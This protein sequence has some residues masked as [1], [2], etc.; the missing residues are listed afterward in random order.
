MDAR[1]RN[2]PPRRRG[3]VLVL[4]LAMLGLLALIGVTFATFSGQ[5]QVG[6]RY[7]AEG[8]AFP[9]S[10][11][12][13]DFGLLNLINDSNNPTSAIRG[14]SLKR[15][16]YGNGADKN[17]YVERELAT[18]L[19]L[20]VSNSPAPTRVNNQVYLTT[21]IPVGNTAYIGFKFLGW[22]LKTYA[23]GTFQVSQTFKIVGDDQS[24][25]YRAFLLADGPEGNTPTATLT[26]PAAGVSFVLDGRYL[27]AFNGGGMNS[28]GAPGAATMTP[29]P[30][31]VPPSPPAVPPAPILRPDLSPVG[32]FANFRYNNGIIND[33]TNNYLGG[34]AE[35]FDF[36]N[37]FTRVA[38]DEDYDAP[39]L[40]NWF[41]AMQSADGQVVIPSFHRPSIIR[42]DENP[43]TPANLQV[44]DWKNSGTEVRAKFLRPRRIDHPGSGGSFP[45]LIPDATTGRITYDIDNDGD[46]VTDSVWLDFGAP[47]QRSATGKLFKAL[48]APMVLG[49]NGRLPLNSAGNLHLRGFDGGLLTGAHP[50]HA[51]HLG[52]STSEINIKY[53]L[54]NHF[55]W[56]P[57]SPAGSDQTKLGGF[58]S[59]VDNVPLLG[60]NTDVS[61]TQLRNLLVGNRPLNYPNYPPSAAVNYAP[62]TTMPASGDGNPVLVNGVLYYLAN[63]YYDAVVTPGDISA[64]RGTAAVPGR[65]GEPSLIPTQNNALFLEFNNPVRAG[66]SVGFLENPPAFPNDRYGI[67]ATDDDFDT[68]DFF[69]LDSM[70]NQAAGELRNLT[71][72]AGYELLPVERIRAFVTPIDPS[73]NGVVTRFNEPVALGLPPHGQGPDA[74]GRVSYFHYFRPPGKLPNVPT[75]P[76]LLNNLLHGLEAQRLPL[77]DSHAQ[78]AAMP[79]D[80]L[81]SNG[82]DV[83]TY[84]ADSPTT[85]GVNSHA[86]A[87]SSTNIFPSGGLAKDLADESNLYQPSRYDALFGPQDL[88][89]LYRQH[90]VDGASLD[91]RLKYLAPISFNH[92]VDGQRRRRLFSLETWETNKYIARTGVDAGIDGQNANFGGP[93][94]N[95]HGS[96]L[97][98]PVAPIVN[99]TAAQQ[100]SLPYYSR[101][102][103]PA[104]TSY[105]D[106]G[107]GVGFA[108]G[109]P[110]LAGSGRRMNLNLPLPAQVIDNTKTP[111]VQACDETVRHRWILDAYLLCRAVLP[112]ANNYTPEECVQLSQFLTNVIDFRDTD[113]VM[114]RFVNPEVIEQSGS[115]AAV[116]PTM[117]KLRFVNDATVPA[118]PTAAN[119]TF[120]PVVQWGMEYN[121]IAINE[122]LATQFNYMTNTPSQ[123]FFIELV[124]T[125]TRDG[126]AAGRAGSKATD[127]DLSKWQ[128]TF[129]PDGPAGR[130]DPFTG[131][132]PSV[133]P[134]QTP[135]TPVLMP[136]TPIA[137]SRAQALEAVDGTTIPPRTTA[138]GAEDI[139]AGGPYPTN[140]Y[141]VAGTPPVAANADT[142]RPARNADL[143][144]P[145]GA[146]PVFGNT[147]TP[148]YGQLPRL[149]FNQQAYY[150]VYLLR[151][152]DPTDANSPLAPV[153][154]MR[155]LMRESS[156]TPPIVST[157]PP[158]ITG[159]TP[160]PASWQRLQPYRGG[161]AIGQVPATVAATIDPHYGLSEQTEASPVVSS[162]QGQW[163]SS[164]PPGQPAAPAVY[165]T[166][167]ARNTSAEAWDYLAFHDRDFMGVAE[168]LLVP[169]CPPNLFTKQFVENPSHR[170]LPTGTLFGFGATPG[171]PNTP[172]Y[173]PP[174]AFAVNDPNYGNPLG[175]PAGGLPSQVNAV[176]VSPTSTQDP[177]AYPYL[178]DKFYYNDSIP[179]PATGHD[180]WYQMLEYFEVPSSAIG[181]VGRVAYGENLDWQRQ[182]RRPGQ[183]NLNLIIDEEVF[184][185]L[186]DDARLDTSNVLPRRAGY[187][188]P[189]VATL[190]RM[191]RA[192]INTYPF[193]QYVSPTNAAATYDSGSFQVTSAGVNQSALKQSFLDFLK[194][195]HG[196]SNDLFS[197]TNNVPALDNTGTPLASASEVSPK[198]YRALSSANIDN[199]ILRPA[200][201]QN[202]AVVTQS[203]PLDPGIRLR[204]LPTVGAT[205]NNR[206]R[207]VLPTRRL[208]QVPD[209][210]NPLTTPTASLSTA[211]ENPPYLQAGAFAPNP[212]PQPVVVF[213]NHMNL[214]NTSAN[215]WAPRVGPPPVPPDFPLYLGGAN[216]LASVP[217]KG[218]TRQHPA[219]RVETLEKMMN[220][221]T[222]RTHQFAVWFTV[223]FFEV[224]QPGNPAGVFQPLTQ[225]TA[226][227]PNPIDPALDQLGQ[228]I[229]LSTGRN[230][231]YRS[232]FLVDRTR[233]T[234][235]NSHNPTDFRE[236]VTYRRRIE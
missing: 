235:L 87:H 223:G 81:A 133:F 138:A 197:Y 161:H 144:S 148:Q 42:V 17:G 139:V 222:T 85:V 187:V 163:Q 114:T 194:L 175:Y 14:H 23:P 71:D 27:H 129:L 153:D 15:D 100:T 211:S 18:G 11:E 4:I 38:M 76:D 147:L 124:N 118:L 90:D 171:A 24:G 75:G 64:I 208:F 41:L 1:Y 233:A 230:I 83:P 204:F 16:M 39:D 212:P 80:L 226:L 141:Y 94:V 20:T 95:S 21:N 36:S 135:A 25:T 160:V 106:D 47:V 78:M 136:I 177:H 178:V 134:A 97:A 109:S 181:A 123:E 122:V 120:G 49:L 137:T 31:P 151:P 193:N 217:P 162:F 104:G 195:R 3:V 13:M 191:D 228:E 12:V 56:D 128:L 55:Q 88:E 89:W 84:Y 199:T 68:D 176:G 10:D 126:G 102:F 210:A 149:G 218:D 190:S 152:S 117:P 143:A 107:A 236:C 33:G 51:S 91:S 119:S 2:M 43:L 22:T 40:E 188:L 77:G 52:T 99:P 142:N 164:T 32:Q 9:T 115:L 172:V 28:I 213:S 131:Q 34:P 72:T 198:P 44:N 170:Y 73:G 185:G 66:R 70:N 5:A 232:F 227:N 48:Y 165:H 61:L 54:Q 60:T 67:D 186:V 234:G 103:P 145:P 219:F 116:P 224:I 19:A 26:A 200:F 62:N 93:L 46:G 209:A 158:T 130:P 216:T 205:P 140:I 220:L 121:P 157:N 50:D 127:L 192:I 189:Q 173:P 69:G 6:A 35:L 105:G 184:L 166:L 155:F 225:P 79:Y 63:G 180:G 92:P 58:N 111:P 156:G 202:S 146:I 196:G 108:Y 98:T 150:W 169:G 82:M 112:N 96:V 59:Q 8:V 229:G 7:F 65:Y 154:C 179:L 167:G 45:D 86:R 215:L 214:L 182:D 159:A 207:T 29:L 206:D 201:L 231:R 37:G 30:P 132:L 203:D 57:A 53:A 113:G 221:T 125:L 183:L 101:P 174:G 110:K 168:L 74:W